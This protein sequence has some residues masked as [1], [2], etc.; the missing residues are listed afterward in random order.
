MSERNM[1]VVL[2]HL[3]ARRR[4]DLAAM[5]PLLALDIVLQ[6]VTDELV[7]RGRHEVL[8]NVRRGLAETAISV[9]IAWS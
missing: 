2:D 3:H 5:K 4:G 8:E 7:C 6:G 1:A 9:S